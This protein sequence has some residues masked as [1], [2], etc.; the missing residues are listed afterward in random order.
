MAHPTV[1]TRSAP[2]PSFAGYTLDHYDKL[3]HRTDTVLRFDAR[4]CTHSRTG[5]FAGDGALSARPIPCKRKSC[6]HCGVVRLRQHGLAI[7]RHSMNGGVVRTGIIPHSRRQAL[8]KQIKRA[9]C[10][11]RW[12]P[13]STHVRFFTTFKVGRPLTT[14]R[15]AVA[16]ENAYAATVRD[17]RQVRGTNGWKMSVP[18]RVHETAWTYLGLAGMATKNQLRVLKRHFPRFSSVNR[19]IDSWTVVPVDDDHRARLLA[20]LRVVAPAELARR[21]AARAESDVNRARVAGRV[22]LP[23]TPLWGGD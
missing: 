6:T 3:G 4:Q 19:D 1:R 11:V 13:T 14:D 23:P 18:E 5:L 20:E 8:H 16:I 21:R 7:L 15:L 12:F 22:T 10:E 17:A 2:C 9:G